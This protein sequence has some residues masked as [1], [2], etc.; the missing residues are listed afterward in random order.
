MVELYGVARATSVKFQLDF[1][2]GREGFRKGFCHSPLII[3]SLLQSIMSPFYQ[4]MDYVKARIIS[5]SLEYTQ[6]VPRVNC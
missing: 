4:L 5:V 2:R 1:Y 6:N 3:V